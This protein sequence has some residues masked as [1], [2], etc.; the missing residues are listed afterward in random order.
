[1]STPETV[2]PPPRRD[3]KSPYFLLRTPDG[4]GS[5]L[6]GENLP[7]VQS[8]KEPLARFLAPARIVETG[9]L[10]SLVFDFDAVPLDTARPMEF[11]PQSEIDAFAE[12]VRAFYDKA[13]AATPR[14]VPHE[15]RLRASFRLPDPEAEADA[16]WVYGPAHDRRLLI[17][18]GCEFR[19]GSSLPLA[20][21]AELKIPSGRTILDRLQARVMSWEGR[22]REALKLALAPG[23]PIS[24]FL[25]RPAVDAGG[26]PVGVSLAGQTI[27]DKKLKPFKRLLTTECAAFEKA[28]VRFYD[29]ARADTAGVTAYEKELR[30]AFRLPDPDKLPAAF[31]LNGKSLVIAVS[32]QE[33]EANTLPMV[34]HPALAPVAPAAAATPAEGPVVV[35]TGAGSGRTVAAKLK[36]RAVSSSLVY[37]IAAAALVVVLVGGLALWKFLPDRTPPKVVDS[38]DNPVALDGHTVMV[39]FSKAMSA[40]SLQ[41]PAGTGA[42]ASAPFIFGNDEAKVESAAPDPKDP[43]RVLLQTSPLVDGKT[44]RLTINGVADRSG[45]KLPAAT[46]VEF[47]YLDSV[48]PK[49]D[50]VSAGDN[51]NNLVLVF[52]KPIAEASVARGG[53]YSIFAMES[54]TEGAAQKITGGHLDPEDKTGRTVILEAAKDFVGNLPYRIDSIAG[55]TDQSVSKNPVAL[56]AK[57]L[58]F[59]Y[60][61][62]LPPRVRGVSASGRDLT[63]TVEFNKAVDAASAENV[64]NYTVTTADKTALQLVKGAAKL[65][66]TGRL[67]TLRLEPARLATGRNLLTVANVADRAGNKIAKPVEYGFEFADAA[68]QGALAIT[69]HDQRGTQLTLTFN[70]ALDPA[71]LSAP[72]KYRILDSEQRPTDITVKEVRRVPENPAKVLLILSKAPPSGS[73]LLVSATDL[74][75]IFGT[76]AAGPVQQRMTIAGVGAASEQVL[77]WIGH[78][79]VKGNTVTLTIQEE[80]ARRT[81]ENLLNYEFTPNTVQVD[82]LRDFKVETDPRSGTRRTIITLV[83]QSPLIS[84]EK[85]TLAVRNLEAEGL[86]FLGAQNLDPISLVAAP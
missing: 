20:P 39:R 25:A 75:D 57:G 31:R 36:A 12:A 16:Y 73:Q 50:L 68:G 59:T 13:H 37:G 55:V 66:A 41:A 34:D 48:A 4:T 63:L 35:A 60:R 19:A 54:G 23:E 72:A 56:P 80:V 65:D 53:N 43:A 7:I 32:G 74:A 79:A 77:R 38:P 45:H 81:A 67:L 26:Q 29:K 71:D 46:S 52:S 70:R 9:T 47:K 64:A 40:A 1:M 8:P 11:L 18:W 21:D 61:D 22:Q 86:A 44:Y 5:Y 6:T 85:V 58:E 17:L 28:A 27:P 3:L 69:A 24:R 14:I 15:K 76:K 10:R 82:H 2:A 84:P 49:I 51:A 62:I 83:L 33:T 42:A 30:R 78:P